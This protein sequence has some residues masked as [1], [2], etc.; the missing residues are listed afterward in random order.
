[1]NIDQNYGKNA[2]GDDKDDTDAGKRDEE[3]EEEED[4]IE[5][6]AIAVI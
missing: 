4:S 3:T 5:S 2:Y 1:V 6:P